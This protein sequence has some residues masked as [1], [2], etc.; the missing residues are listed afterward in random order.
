MKKLGN[1]IKNKYNIKF[2]IIY[3]SQ[4]IEKNYY[5]SDNNIYFIKLQKHIG[6]YGKNGLFYPTNKYSEDSPN[7]PWK[8][9]EKIISGS[10]LLHKTNIQQCIN[11]IYN[12]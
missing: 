2:I 4:H 10:I 1:H 12:S 5:D 7:K 9:M 6:D 3:L 8:I 11:E